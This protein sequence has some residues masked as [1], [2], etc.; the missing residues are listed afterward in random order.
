M[1]HS[2]TDTIFKK[3]GDLIFCTITYVNN[4]N[5]FYNTKRSE[6]NYISH[7]DVKYYSKNG[8][9][10]IRS[11]SEVKRNSLK[12][13]DSLNIKDSAIIFLISPANFNQSTFKIKMN[14]R[15]IYELKGGEIIKCVFFNEGEL[16]IMSTETKDGEQVSYQ[17]I[18]LDLEFPKTH[19]I[20]C[21]SAP[22]ETKLIDEQIGEDLISNKPLTIIEEDL[23]NP[24]IRSALFSTPKTGTGFLLTETGLVVTNYHVIEKAKKIELSG[25]NGSFD[26][27][28]TAKVVVEDK[29][30]DLAILQIENK[31]A[32][33]DPTPYSIRS[34]NAETG[35]DIFVLGYPMIRSMGE[36]IK[37]TTGVISAKTGYKGDV[38]TYQVSA[39][40]QGGNSGGPLFDKQGNVVGI[41]N[42]KILGAEG[43]TYAIKTT[44]LNSL[45][46]LLPN[47]PVLNEFSKL[48]KLTLEEQVKLISRFVYIIKIN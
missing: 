44:Y 36:E 28:Y 22:G 16:K 21:S 37:L 34:K 24:I 39:P 8:K 14:R 46:D 13:K 5:I 48:D 30:N 1:A 25:I 11:L 6:G 2:Q 15:D 47:K 33:Y 3:D 35:E 43:V 40:V 29:K 7:D 45:I 41:I 9:R 23:L 18:N 42:A 26:K 4:N 38:T 12:I 17:I 31:D 27:S 19:Y 20:F 32:K 10:A